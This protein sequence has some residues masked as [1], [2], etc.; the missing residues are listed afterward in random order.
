MAIAICDCQ[1]SYRLMIP[2]NSS[3]ILAVLSALSFL[4]ASNALA[5]DTNSK[6]AIDAVTNNDSLLR[7]ALNSYERSEKQL[8]EKF[9]EELA[10]LNEA[11]LKAFQQAFDRASSRR[12][13]EA[14]GSLA[15]IINS[16]KDEASAGSLGTKLDEVSPIGNWEF[17]YKGQSRRFR[18]AEDKSFQGQY[19]VSGKAFAGTWELSKDRIVLKRPGEKEEVFATISTRES[20]NAKLR[21]FNGHAMSG[22]KTD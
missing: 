22:R 6:T 1:L 16:M 5:S 19:A 18:F 2:R 8:R 14:I 17:E 20:K 13:T 11:R 12:D 10:A 7:S 9:G 21:Q 4:H 3:A 15:V